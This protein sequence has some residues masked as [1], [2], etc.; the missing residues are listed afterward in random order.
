MQRLRPLGSKRRGKDEENKKAFSHIFSS[1]FWSNLPPVSATLNGASSFLPLPP[2]LPG[3][4]RRREEQPTVGHRRKG[5]GGGGKGRATARIEISGGGA[6]LEVAY[7]TVLTKS[8]VTEHPPTPEGREEGRK[9][10]YSYWRL[11]HDGAPPPPLNLN[12]TADG[13]ESKRG[14]EQHPPSY[15]IL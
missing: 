10:R 5:R 6:P 7:T 4:A 1:F 8:R 14:G 15:Y 11:S 12:L 13:E 3:E 2:P 9:N